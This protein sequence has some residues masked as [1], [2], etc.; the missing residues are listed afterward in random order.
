MADPYTQAAMISQPWA[1]A[2]SGIFD[3][4]RMRAEG[5]LKAGIANAQRE[6]ALAHANLFDQQSAKV[7]A[8]SDALAQRRQYQTPEFSNKIAAALTG[9]SDEQGQQLSGFQSRG[10]WGESR[11][12]ELPEG[13]E[14]PPMPVQNAQPAWFNPQL[15][16]RFNQARGAHLANLGATGNTNAEQMTDA[17]TKL[18]GQN[19]IDSAMIDPKQ[20][21]M[22][23]RAMAASQ[24]KALFHQGANGVM[25]QFSGKETI[26]DVGRSAI[27]EN[28]AQANQANAS[29]AQHIASRDLTRSKIGQVQTVTMPDGA[30]VISGPPPK[31]MPVA[32][33]KLIQEENDELKAASD[34]VTKTQNYIEQLEKGKLKL[35][36]AS[37]FIG[38][39]RNLAGMSDDNSKNLASFKADLEKMRND[40][41]RLNK[42]VQ[43][44]GDAQRAWNELFA[45][46][47][48]EGVVKQRLAEIAKYNQSAADFRRSNINAIRANFNHPTVEQKSQQAQVPSPRSPD[49]FISVSNA[50]KAIAQGKDRDAV[51]RRLE[52]NGITDHGL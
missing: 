2:F 48:D 11:G 17:Y 21:E 29:A 39:A 22:L 27:L 41:L 19:R 20:A 4:Q 15:Q 46:I 30:T 35:S 34:T 9:L 8:E 45:N 42:G 26:N 36:P 23:G 7:K 6:Q 33:L 1:R 14:G 40:S 12:A 3:G 52:E 43:T 49:N 18:L 50:R 28:K 47:N 51:I 25:D 44:E 31:P 10:N 24:G 13:Q 16:Q 5:E 32:A 37:N 38:Q